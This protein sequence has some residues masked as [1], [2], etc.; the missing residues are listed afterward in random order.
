MIDESFVEARRVALCQLKEELLS[1]VS[2]AAEGAKPVDLD[3]PIGR[4]SRVDAMQQQKM[5]AVNRQAAQQRRR[6]VDAALSRIDEGDFGE[7][8]GC[9]E[10]IDPRR[11]EAQPEAPFCIECQG[12]REAAG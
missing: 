10:E 4:V 12:R 2:S 3:E 6:L 11:L 5:V 1:V 8:L 7:C 9:G